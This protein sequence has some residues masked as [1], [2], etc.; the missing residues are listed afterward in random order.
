M[1]TP[2][3]HPPDKEGMSQAKAQGDHSES[4]PHLELRRLRM[5]LLIRRFEERTFQI[6]SGPGPR[7]GGFSH[8][9]TGQEAVATGVAEVLQHERD[10]LIN[11]FR[12]HG[13]SLALGMPPAAAMAELFGRVTGCCRG[14]G[15]S[16]HFFDRPTRNLGGWYVAGTHIPL[17]VGAAFAC[18]YRNTGGV[19]FVIFGDGAT[20]QGALH[21]ALNLASL[22]KLPAVFIC[23]D[24]GIALG[25]SIDRHSAD[26]DLVKRGAGCDMPARGFDGNDLDEVIRH[27]SEAADRARAGCGPTLLVARTYRLRGFMMS[28]PMKYRRTPDGQWLPEVEEALRR[29]PI[30]RY[31]ERLTETGLLDRTTFDRLRQ[32]VTDEVEGGVSFAERSPDPGVNER[33]ADVL[34]EQYPLRK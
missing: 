26:P 16:M 24:N 13:Y 2:F 33:F 11:T 20:N 9:S 17:G 18:R 15:G 27:V 31:A 25:T 28:D 6:Y 14:K 7:I 4:A 8:L 30:R 23:E 1:S 12:C 29:D 5:M 34:A 3:T 22:M 32:D 10:S 19:C 21:E